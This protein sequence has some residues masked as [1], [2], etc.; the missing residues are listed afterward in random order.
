MT[1]ENIFYNC[2]SFKG[3]NKEKKGAEF[4][5]EYNVEDPSFKAF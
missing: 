4:K 5:Y 3:D 1:V 2:K